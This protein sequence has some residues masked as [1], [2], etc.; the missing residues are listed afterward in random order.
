MRLRDALAIFTA[1]TLVVSIPVTTTAAWLPD[2]TA[3]QHHSR[4][5]LGS[6]ETI[7]ETYGCLIE[8]LNCKPGFNWQIICDTRNAQNAS[9]C[10]CQWCAAYC[11]VVE[12]T[13]YQCGWYPCL[14][15]PEGMWIEQ[16]FGCGCRVGNSTYDR[17]TNCDC[18][19]IGTSDIGCGCGHNCMPNPPPNPPPSPPSSP[20]PPNPPPNPPPSPPPPN[21]PSSPP[22]NPPPPNSPPNPPPPNPPP[23]PA[24]PK[25]TREDRIVRATATLVGARSSAFGESYRRGFRAAIASVVGTID[26]DAVDIISVADVYAK[27]RRRRR[28]LTNGSVGSAAVDVEYAVYIYDDGNVDNDTS[29]STSAA[30]VARLTNISSALRSASLGDALRAQG[31]TDV[32]SASTTVRALAVP[33]P[34]PPPNAPTDVAFVG[35]GTGDGLESQ[36]PARPDF[37]VERLAALFSGAAAMLL[38][39]LAYQYRAD[40]KAYLIERHQR[41]CRRR[42]S[43]STPSPSPSSVSLKMPRASNADGDAASAFLHSAAG[44]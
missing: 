15:D 30:A 21:P 22:P 7:E 37:T 20:P 10:T 19:G 18:R 2:A 16:D 13:N 31:L 17:D 23:N 12:E 3:I 28:L 35:D 36:V 38:G 29:S 40:I 44:L 43:S 32:T 42:S 11:S 39:S 25:P 9:E 26:A 41:R 6:A 4:A 34:P 24:P 8:S 1:F 27:K 33:P 14:E 5:L